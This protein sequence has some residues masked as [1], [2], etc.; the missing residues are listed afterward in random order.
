[1]KK[2][3]NQKQFTFPPKTEMQRVLKRFAD[4]NYHRV[5]QGLTPWATDLDRAKYKLCKSILRYKQNSNLNSKDIAKQLG[6]TTLKAEYILYSH[7][8]KFTLDELASYAN[9][10]HVPC[11]PANLRPYKINLTINKQRFVKVEI[12]PLIATVK[13]P[14][15]GITDELIIYL[16]KQLDGETVEPDEKKYHQ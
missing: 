7:I 8:D 12:N 13:H 6:I 15:E 1:M 4:P 14:N 9:N 5:N 3:L 2:E 10:L 11:Q 16:L